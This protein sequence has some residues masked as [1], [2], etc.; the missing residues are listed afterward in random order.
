KKACIS[1]LRLYFTANNVYTF[2]NYSGYDPNVSSKNDDVICTPGFDSRAYPT[3][4]S[5]VVG[6]NLSF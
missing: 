5:Y 4:R 6:L 1:N 2:T 3:S